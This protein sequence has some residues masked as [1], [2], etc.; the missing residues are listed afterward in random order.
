MGS[1]LSTSKQIINIFLQLHEQYGWTLIILI[2]AMSTSALFEG[3]GMAMLLP[4][5]TSLGVGEP[6][7]SSTLA[8]EL[9]N[10]L[11]FLSIE[12]EPIQLSLFIT[13][14]LLIQL[15]LVVCVN[16][17]IAL[18]QRDFG[19]V[20][21]KRLFAGL[22]HSNYYYV[23][24][25]ELG[26]LT[27]SLTQ[28]IARVSG[29]VF[30][31]L[32]LC[33]ISI[34]T[35]FYLALSLWISWKL[36]IVIIL[37]CCFLFLMVRKISGK[38][39]SI[40][41]QIGPINSELNVNFTEY[42]SSI[43]HIKVTNTQ[44]YVVSKA[45]LVIDKLTGMHVQASFLPALVRAIFEFGSIISFCYLLIISRDVFE[46]SLISTVLILGLFVRLLPRFTAIQQNLQNL[47]NYLSAFTHIQH[48]VN[49]CE[50]KEEKTLL[51]PTKLE[52][53]KTSPPSGLFLDIKSCKA[54]DREVLQNIQYNFPEK[55]LFGIT[56]KSGAGKTSLGNVIL[57]LLSSGSL[58]V[59]V[60][61]HSIS[62]VTL[63]EWRENISYVSQDISL[64]HASIKDN[65]AW[66][67]A[68][69]S[70]KQIEQAA[71]MASAHEFIMEKPDN[72]MTV[73]GD[74]G[75]KLSGGQRQRIALAQALLRRPKILILDEAT[76]SLDNTTANEILQNVETLREQM[77][78]ISITH[79]INTLSN[80]DAILVLNNGKLEAAGTFEYLSKECALFREILDGDKIEK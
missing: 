35:A 19:A 79:K 77:C 31:I 41:A 59:S 28:E 5:L 72:Y 47:G 9:N 10:L 43:K 33:S 20:W 7:A 67:V 76:S 26:G 58:D 74:R 52:A 66:G 50:L 63:R 48:F 53:Q 64:F 34:T 80:H 69:A 49:E 54:G 39:Y 24:S 25:K 13:F 32:Q 27:N 73:V 68:D 23:S 65:I 70:M 14:V 4:L 1:T 46:T 6:D 17:R 3:I 40:G 78:I 30:I 12:N 45:N 57:G 37:V 16:W 15:M 71:R 42:L 56:G 29:S 2:V 21:Q 44:N 60:N 11:Q 75:V 38:N 61:G 51:K 36:T 55:G 8:L 18:V 62:H 22:I